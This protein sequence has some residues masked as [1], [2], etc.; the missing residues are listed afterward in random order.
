MRAPDK[1]P[2]LSGAIGSLVLAAMT[3]PDIEEVL[4]DFRNCLNDYDTWAEQFWS[5]D[6]LDLKQV[7]KVGDEVSL[8][9][10]ANG[11]RQLSALVARC[12]A[13]GPLTL[14]H[15]FQTA[16]F[17]PIGDTPVVL[18]P[19][20]KDKQ[21]KVTFGDPIPHVIGPSGILEIP[22]CDRGQ[23]YRISFFPNV[24][25][26]HVKALYASYQLAI[27]ELEGWLKAE[28]NAFQPLWKEHSE[29]GFA[30]RFDALQEAQLR[31]FEHGESKQLAQPLRFQGQY[32]DPESG[33]HYNRH[34]YYNPETGRYLTP[35]PS[36]L[37]AGSM[38]IG[39]P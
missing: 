29:S 7:F 37:A 3:S 4:Q 20:I 36:K 2:S 11:G 31:G 17:V 6:A 12:P 27:V 1:F 38:G 32:H 5:G 30:K 16:R 24:T 39:T 18:E 14:V 21:G 8:G 13:Q 25:T 33:L 9:P 23:R 15:M 19:I 22:E 28:W 10:M 34:R 26:D 35:D